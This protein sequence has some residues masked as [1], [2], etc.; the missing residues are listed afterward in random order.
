MQFCSDKF[1]F[2]PDKA[3]TMKKALWIIVLVILSSAI[4]AQTRTELKVADIQKPVSEY[5]TKN[6]PGYTV[7]KAFKVDSKGNITFEICVT[8]QKEHE[9]ITFDKDGKFL[10]K[11]SCNNE[12]CKVP[13][14]K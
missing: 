14:K 4:F 6:Y 5:L 12:C 1:I 8:K 3:G 7:D 11:E 9:K 2:I 10:K 13:I